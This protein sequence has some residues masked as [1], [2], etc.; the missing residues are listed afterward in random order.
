MLSKANIIVLQADSPLSRYC[1]GAEMDKK[2]KQKSDSSRSP[3]GCSHQWLGLRCHMTRI[4][5]LAIIEVFR[6]K[7]MKKSSAICLIIRVSDVF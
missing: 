5:F 4:V 3:G 1:K 7:M 2:E 6:D